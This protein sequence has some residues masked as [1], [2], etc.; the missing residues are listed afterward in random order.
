MT[1]K[2][3]KGKLMK[4]KLRILS[5]KK[6]IVIAA[7]ILGLGAFSIALAQYLDTGLPE[8]RDEIVNLYKQENDR[9]TAHIEWQNDPEIVGYIVEGNKRG[10]ERQDISII[11][12]PEED[13]MS[14]G[15]DLVLEDLE[16]NTD[17]QLFVTSFDNEG[18]TSS[19][20]EIDFLT[21]EE[22]CRPSPAGIDF[23]NPEER[24]FIVDTNTP[25]AMES[26][27]I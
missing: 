1:S 3:T 19:T 7:T 2:K 20:K 22:L 9:V 27:E 21:A 10:E 13:E 4:K 12:L 17:Y 25:E 24:G 6:L 14:N 8:P 23:V 18:S 5:N 16:K 11:E 26:T 15:A